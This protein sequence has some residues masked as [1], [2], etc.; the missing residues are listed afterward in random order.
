MFRQWQMQSKFRLLTT[1]FSPIQSWQMGRHRYRNERWSRSIL[2]GRGR[3]LVSYWPNFHGN[4]SPQSVTHLVKLP[5]Y[6]CPSITINRILYEDLQDHFEK[7]TI[8]D[9]MLEAEEDLSPCLQYK[10]VIRVSE[11][12]SPSSADDWCDPQVRLNHVSI[13]PQGPATAACFLQYQYH[14][15]AFIFTEP[16]GNQTFHK[17]W[18]DIAGS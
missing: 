17:L 5:T 4:Q 13:L 1:K 9:E 18:E 10:S 15:W 16:G 3:I 14:S 12:G 6:S 11:A 2:R 7:L 8:F